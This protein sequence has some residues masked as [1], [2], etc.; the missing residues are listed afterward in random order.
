MPKQ[1]QD[2]VAEVTRPDGGC[3]SIVE[4][5]SLFPEVMS[6]IFSAFA[7]L[8][9]TGMPLDRRQQEMIN[10]VVSSVNRCHY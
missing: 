4:A 3:D 8:V 10:T 2:L 7:K 6:D 9:S 1:Y 5:H